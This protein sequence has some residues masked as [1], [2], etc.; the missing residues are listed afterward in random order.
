ME[1]VW[2]ARYT[3]HFKDTTINIQHNITPRSWTSY[4]ERYTVH[5]HKCPTLIRFW[6]NEKSLY[7]LINNLVEPLNTTRVSF[8]PKQKNEN[9][10]AKPLDTPS[11][12]W[13][14]RGILN[15]TLVQKLGNPTLGV[16]FE[17]SQKCLNSILICILVCRKKKIVIL[18]SW[19]LNES[20]LSL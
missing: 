2:Y 12:L 7:K 15:G 4:K 9:H 19:N 5:P 16:S 6:K 1:H 14:P 3:N 17:T 11:T 18:F 13:I 8:Q 10:N 20:S